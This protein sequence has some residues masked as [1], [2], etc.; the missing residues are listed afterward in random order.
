MTSKEL[1][2]ILKTGAAELGITVGE[3]EAALFLKYLAE[4][5]EWNKKINLTAITDERE[6]VIRHFLDSLTLVSFLANRKSLLDM[7]SG[8]GF[9]GIPLKIVLPDLKITLM[10]SINKKVVFMRHIIRM[11]GL[12]NIEAVQARV[13]DPKSVKKFGACFDVVTSR[14]FAELGKFLE[15]ALP[16][17]KKGGALLAVKGPKW[18][19]EIGGLKKFK[20]IEFTGTKQLRIPFSDIL[21]T[22]LIFRKV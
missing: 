6:I 5:K 22:I 16:Y 4:L 12:K 14:A 8:A 7:G 19:E 15:S 9:P 1:K 18:S 20:D 17:A 13:E 2:H 21:T 3:R 10:D 11:L